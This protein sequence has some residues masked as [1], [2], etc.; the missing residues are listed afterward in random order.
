M[1]WDQVLPYIIAAFPSV[2]V[3][4]ISMMQVYKINRNNFKKDKNKVE[5][6]R[7]EEK[8]QK[9]YYPY[10][11]IARKN[12]VIY[13]IFSKKYL[14]EDTNYRTLISLLSGFKFNG[15]DKALLDEIINNDIKL[16]KL[17]MEK[18]DVIDDA[19]IRE[20]L[21]DSS[22]HYTV[23]ELAYNGSLVGETERFYEFVHPNGVYEEVH[24]KVRELEARIEE[25]KNEQ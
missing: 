15:N 10:L 1:N 20:L 9:F 4:V 25:L 19:K 23:I 11:V 24:K 14:E 21:I 13:K 22:T 16:N 3:A 17:I 6:G 7:L 8:L 5:I 18:A 2:L 12:T